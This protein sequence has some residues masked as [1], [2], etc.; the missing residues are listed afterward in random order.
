MCHVLYN[1]AMCLLMREKYELAFRSL[2]VATPLLH[3]LPT[4]WLRLAQC[5]VKLHE[6]N[7]CSFLNLGLLGS[8]HQTHGE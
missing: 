3:T 5:C 2:V 6:Q 4:L 7:V 1:N 8:L